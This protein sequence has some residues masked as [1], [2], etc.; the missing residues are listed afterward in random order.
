MHDRW[1]KFEEFLKDVG[2][3]PSAE[4]TLDR[5]PNNDGNYE[6]G[7]IRWATRSEQQRNRRQNRLITFNG[8]TKCLED[9]AKFADMHPSVLTYRL[10]IGLT[11]GEAINGER[12]YWHKRKDP[13][14]GKF[15][16][17]K[18]AVE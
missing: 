16:P 10:K 18:K 5:Y 14:T 15:L 2:R 4:Y 1:R 13:R 9:W 17:Y 12:L 11:F 7:N 3:R 6:P 8:E